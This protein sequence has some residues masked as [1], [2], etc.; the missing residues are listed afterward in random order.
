MN[1]KRYIVALTGS[2]GAG[3]STVARLFSQEGA[4]VIDADDLA[5]EAVKPGSSVLNAMIAQFGNAILD[6]N[7][8]LNRSEF[9]KRIFSNK[10]DREKAEGL[11]H[12]EVSRL[13]H[14]K[15]EKILASESN[16]DPIIIYVIPLLFEAKIDLNNF[17]KI[18]VVSA[19]EELLIERI[20]MRDKSTKAQALAILKSQIPSDEKETLADIVI[21]NNGS[22][23]ELK[24]KVSHYYK[25]FIQEKEAKYKSS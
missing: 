4:I 12:P 1:T 19:A 18:V 7:G 25:M 21:T 14:D 11:I 2:I 9:A 24:S 17:D 5:R 23:E 3:K 8:C 13:F 20:I 16:T 22:I 6:K 10:N 15:L